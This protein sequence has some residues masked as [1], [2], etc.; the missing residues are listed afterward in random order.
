MIIYPPLIADIIPAFLYSDTEVVI[1]I[2]FTQNPAV[3]AGI[4]L[5][6]QIKDY[7]SSIIITKS[8]IAQQ[9]ND[10]QVSFRFKVE[11]VDKW[12]IQTVVNGKIYK[13]PVVG[14]YY[15]IQIAYDDGD[16]GVELTYSSAVLGKCIDNHIDLNITDVNGNILSS[17]ENNVNPITYVGNYIRS[18]LNEPLY[19]YRFDFKNEAGEI[20]ETS[21]EIVWNNQKDKDECVFEGWRISKNTPIKVSTALSNQH[22]P[23]FTSYVVQPQS[24]RGIFDMDDK[25]IDN[26]YYQNFTYYSDTILLSDYLSKV[27]KDYS[28]FYWDSSPSPPLVGTGLG[29]WSLSETDFKML[30]KYPICATKSIQIQKLERDTVNDLATIEVGERSL[31]ISS[32]Y[33]STTPTYN[34]KHELQMGQIYT[35][36]FSTTTI[37]GYQDSISVNIIKGDLK[38]P[39]FPVTLEVI[40]NKDM[41]NNEIKV[42]IETYATITENALNL[43]DSSARFGIRWDYNQ[44]HIGKFYPINFSEDHIVLNQT[45]SSLIGNI[46]IDDNIFYTTLALLTDAS[47][48]DYLDI[49]HKSKYL[50]QGEYTIKFTNF[51]Y[52]SDGVNRPYISFDNMELSLDNTNQLGVIIRQHN[53]INETVSANLL[54]NDNTVT[55]GEVYKYGW[56]ENYQ[57][58]AKIQWYEPSI[59]TYTDYIFLSDKDKQLK[60]SFNPKVSSMKETILETK[61][62]TIG[63]KYPIFY[64]NGQVRYREIPIS[65][66]ISYLMDDYEQFATNEELGLA[67]ADRA[68]TTS[69][70]NYNIIAERKFRE[71][72]LNW[73]NDGKPK[74]FRSMTEG[75]FIVRLMNVSLSPNDTVGRMIWTFSATAYEI[76]ENTYDNLKKHKLIET[77]EEE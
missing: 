5:Q 58:P 37:N 38:E 50:P 56:Q 54:Y 61:Q 31:T 73:L 35:M 21:G 52:F 27:Y 14:Q 24:F 49:T 65:G 26:P 71:K 64:R 46:K 40:S 11:D 16:E 17:N 62:D 9:A 68:R 42:E 74:L 66:L 75:A 1:T 20:I 51:Y 69:L 32:I 19:S 29:D 48:V 18:Q 57:G 53:D 23:V 2:P 72:V 44:E 47:N 59:T 6:I 12:P 8:Q 70:T 7:F 77:E 39:N 55:F 45:Y 60:I 67:A 28:C 4:P 36:T 76:D 33:Q 63:G 43:N 3:P 30:Q 10:G 25:Y 22:D 34:L 15:K 13:F 41:G